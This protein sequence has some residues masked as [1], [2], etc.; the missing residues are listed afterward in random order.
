MCPLEIQSQ[1]CQ[2][3][4]QL[5]RCGFLH[6][7]HH[8]PGGREASRAAQKASAACLTS[9]F[10]PEPPNGRISHNTGFFLLLDH[11]YYYFFKYIFF[12]PLK[13]IWSQNDGQHGPSFLLLRLLRRPAG[14]QNVYHRYRNWA[15]EAAEEGEWLRGKRRVGKEQKKVEEGG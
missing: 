2:G 8:Q 3:V 10:G 4:P 5:A 9:N 1:A 12:V 14:G 11:Y 13:P 15:S 7:C 6:T